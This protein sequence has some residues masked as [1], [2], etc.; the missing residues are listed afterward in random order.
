M[1]RADNIKDPD[2]RSRVDGAYGKLRGGDPS[3]AVR[4]LSDAFIDTLSAH[5]ELLEVTATVR[6]R[7]IPI[8]AR[9]P[10]FGANLVLDPEHVAPP[11][12]DFVRE[13]FAVSEALTYFEFLVDLAQDHGL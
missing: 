11:R 12:I 1:G 9:W 13:R 7:A 10:A 8:V 6:G 2:L 5:P 3:G 4:M